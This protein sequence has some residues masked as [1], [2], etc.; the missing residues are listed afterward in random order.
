M[1]YQ[2]TKISIDKVSTN[3]KNPRL[4]KDS[5]FI[6]LV[7]SIK[8]F[9]E[10]LNLRPIV[11]D[12]Q[13]IVIGGNMRLKACQELGWKEIP[14]INA[15]DLT[16]EQIQQFVIK[17]NIG[18]GEWDYEIIGDGWKVQDLTDWGF[19]FPYNPDEDLFDIEEENQEKLKDTRPSVTH[20]DYSAFE[21][22]MLHE[23]KLLLMATLNNAK[24]LYGLERLEDAMMVLVN[25]YNEKE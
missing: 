13:G 10:M 3:K 25:Q 7:E 18:F 2:I 19:E 12:D 14:V 4:I 6:K 17:D 16:E 8:E 20:D 24:E 5:R 11:V 15:K 21:L 1:P 22:V 23:N 9:P